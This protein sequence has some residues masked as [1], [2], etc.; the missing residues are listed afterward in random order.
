MDI[1]SSTAVGVTAGTNTYMTGYYWAGTGTFLPSQYSECTFSAKGNALDHNT[2]GPA[3]LIQSTPSYYF[4]GYVAFYSANGLSINKLVNAQYSSGT[5]LATYGHTLAVGDVVRLSAVPGASST[6]LTLYLNGTPVATAVDSS[7][8]LLTGTPGI[9]GYSYNS[10]N[11]LFEVTPWSAGNNVSAGVP[12]SL[13]L[14]G[15]GT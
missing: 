12:N 5:V 14:M 10:S 3:V 8:P 13:A 2:L 15:C 9:W 7:S 1:I 11:T 6:A 4:T